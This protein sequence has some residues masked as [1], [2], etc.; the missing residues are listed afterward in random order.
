MSHAVEKAGSCWYAWIYDFDEGAWAPA[1]YECA[2]PTSF[3]PWGEIGWSIWESWYLVGNPGCPSVGSIRAVNILL[4]EPDSLTWVPVDDYP[5]DVFA[6]TGQGTCWTNNGGNG[7]YTFTYPL[8]SG[9]GW[10]TNSWQAV[11]AAS[12]PLSVTVNGPSVVGPNNHTCSQWLASVQNGASPLQYEW[13]GLFTGT[14]YYVTGTIPTQGGE[15]HVHVTDG[16]GWQGIGVITV[17]YDS[18]N[19]DYCI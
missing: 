5:S 4:L 12:S 10:P 19:T 1:I 17:T 6:P 16:N 9:T 14:D 3:A 13:T 18:G 2:N 7:P 11:T 8:S 15:L